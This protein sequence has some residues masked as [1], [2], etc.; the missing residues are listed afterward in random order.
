MSKQPYI[1]NNSD[2][3]F[4]QFKHMTIESTLQ[5]SDESIKKIDN[6]RH[7]LDKKMSDNDTLYYGINT[8]FGF[9]Q[10]V[11]IDKEQLE[12][13]QENLIKSHA[14]GLGDEVPK[15]IVKL[16]LLLKIKSLS[17]GHSGVQTKT[18]E[19]L[20]AMYNKNILPVIYTQGSLG[21][22]GDLAPLSHL[23]LPLLG[24]GEVYMN[25]AK[26]SSS[27]ALQ[28]NNWEPI[29]L[30]SKEGLALINGT[31]FILS[32]AIDLDS[33]ILAS[34]SAPTIIFSNIFIL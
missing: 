7:Y 21:A 32:P 12:V 15:E 22:S 11:K 14:C 33:D 9:L 13:L 34:V 10:N 8:G 26:I 31:Q 24:L 3:E 29:A 16:M 18:V 6:C 1:I 5:L 28:Q 20:V 19:R 2:I 4:D 25:D 30:Q 27:A 17:Y 23:S